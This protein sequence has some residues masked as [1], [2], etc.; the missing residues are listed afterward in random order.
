MPTFQRASQVYP[1]GSQTFP[2]PATASHQYTN[3]LI[4][5]TRESWPGTTSDVIARIAVQLQDGTP[6]VSWDVLG[7]TFLKNGVPIATQTL[8]Y[9]KPANLPINTDLQLHVDVMQSLRTAITV[10]VS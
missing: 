1:V 10:T 6:V 9:T 4:T 3:A 5:L 8:Q 2:L 7:G